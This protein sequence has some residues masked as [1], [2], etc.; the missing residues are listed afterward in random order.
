MSKEGFNANSFHTLIAASSKIVST[1]ALTKEIRNL[2]R[3]IIFV[4][5][6]LCI[7]IGTHN[8]TY[9]IAVPRQAVGAQYSVLVYIAHTNKSRQIDT[10][11]VT[12]KT[13]SLLVLKND[14]NVGTNEYA[15]NNEANKTQ[16][17]DNV[18]FIAILH[19]KQLINAIP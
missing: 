10:R 3:L 16:N 15:H 14:V 19:I 9:P 8:N 13:N 17:H 12:E 2:R 18:W 11:L 6:L 5:L 4:R 1:K 7:S